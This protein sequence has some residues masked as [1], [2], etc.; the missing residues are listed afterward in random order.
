MTGGSAIILLVRHRRSLFTIIQTRKL[1][2]RMVA[3]SREIAEMKDFRGCGGLQCTETA[4]LAVP[5]RYSLADA[6]AAR[7]QPTSQQ[8]AKSIVDSQASDVGSIPIARSSYSFPSNNLAIFAAA[9]GGN[10]K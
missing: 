9:K 7:M 3:G 8:R 10:K 5:F 1:S 2:I 6:L 4:I